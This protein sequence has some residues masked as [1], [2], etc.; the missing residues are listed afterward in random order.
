MLQ[1]VVYGAMAYGFYKWC[2]YQD[3]KDKV[4]RKRKIREE[5]ILWNDGKCPH[6]GRNWH[7][8]R[9]FPPGSRGE[10]EYAAISCRRCKT[11]AELQCFIPPR[12]YGWKDLSVQ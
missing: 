8:R 10:Y 9:F 4:E 6:C 3:E 7:V 12:Y 2:K 5:K 1:F 11:R